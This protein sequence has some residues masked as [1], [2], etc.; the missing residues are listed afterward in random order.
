MGS[1]CV[2]KVIAY[3]EKTEDGMIEIEIDSQETKVKKQPKY[4]FRGSNHGML[5]K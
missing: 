1:K 4:G 2:N 5:I 3:E